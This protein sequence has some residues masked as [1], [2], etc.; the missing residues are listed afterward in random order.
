[1]D[2]L[3]QDLSY[4][5]RGLRRSPGFAVA[6]ILTLAL[7]IGANTAIFSVIDAV[8]LRPLPYANPGQL[9]R[10]YE[11]EAAPGNY[12]FTGPDFLDWKT[13]NTTFQDM[14]LL[15]WGQDL[16]L[17]HAGQPDHVIGIP[18]E[19][20]FFSIL[21]ARTLLG[22][23][24]APGEDEPG[25]DQVVV[26]SY[27][28]WQSHF[29][30]DPKVVGQN[31]DL[32]GRKCEIVGVMPAGFHFPAG[33]QLW[34]P[35]LMDSK[36]LG[37]RGSHSFRA[38]GRLK[39]GITLEQAQSEMTLIAKRLEQQYP[40]S[41]HRVGASLVAL[42]EDQVGSSRKSLVMMMWAVALVLLI[43]CANVANLLLSRAVVRQREMA[44]RQALGATRV[45]LIA[46]LLTESV[47]L[48]I[49]GGSLGLSL[50]VGGVKLIEHY[51]AFSLHRANAADLN[52]TVLGFTFLLAVL[53]GLVF[54]IFP[55]LQTSNSEGFDDLKG[56]AGSTPTATRSRKIAS[57]SLVVVEVGIS[58]LLLVCAG[59]LLKDFIRLRNTNI[60]VRS[61]G[62]L[63]AAVTL[64]DSKYGKSE[65]QFALS[66]SFLDKVQH[67]PGVESAALST[68]LP[69]EGGNNGYI[70]V[71]GRP[72]EKMGGPLVE[73][74]R[75][76]PDYYR[77]M[78]IPLVQGRNFTDKDVA[79]SAAM[80]ARQEE[81][82]K[83]TDHP[84]VDATNALIYPVIINQTMVKLFWP[85]ENPIGQMYSHNDA[86]G[87][88]YQV[89]GVVG[90]V[91]EWGLTHEPVSEGY[92]PFNS[93]SG[94]F[95]VVHSNGDTS[96]L[97]PAIR[98]ALRQIDPTLPLFQIRTID[99]VVA[100]NSSGEQFI[101]VLLGTF[102]ALALLL[103]AIGIYGV[104]SYLVTQRTREFGIRMAL[105]AAPGE[106]LKHVLGQGMRLTGIGFALGILGALGAAQ[107]I[108]GLLFTVKPHDPVIYLLTAGGL[109]LVA[110]LAC[111]LPARR[112]ATVDPMVA[113][114]HE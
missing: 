3:L 89:V 52:S 84:P 13:Q 100:D 34:I 93:G 86:D 29:G 69:L 16:N 31:V 71:R 82:F 42:Q 4:A 26:L 113:L 47:M 112:A 10:L 43:A 55:S 32:D 83:N 105:G 101:T 35:L 80:Q 87:P 79:D 53:T 106:V 88:W 11:T 48:A 5:L 59:L 74:H 109:G 65:Q 24:W 67:L 72:S 18:T 7:G 111:A 90:D 62:V 2:S 19:S 98:E 60:G 27:S 56:G 85:N 17:S 70:S 1:M 46:Q 114:R 104:L 92:T 58:L 64:P 6:A 51:N 94:F 45:R 99:D 28:L 36:H 75:V 8:L 96:S 12:P 66:R 39:P 20:N 21:G 54:G 30:G 76:T 97:A 57:D 103:A 33:A 41:N 44:I 102:A 61:Q 73:V 25:K 40:D 110:L 15:G 38:I 63:T 77:V 22:R 107:L 49:A 108:A 78:G 14:A 9:V 95:L 91:K 68:R 23:T 50:A 37:P 81:L